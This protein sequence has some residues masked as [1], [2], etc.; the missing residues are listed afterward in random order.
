V[1]NSASRISTGLSLGVVFAENNVNPGDALCAE[2]EG[3]NLWLSQANEDFKQPGIGLL[4]TRA[5]N[6]SLRSLSCC[7]LSLPWR[8]CSDVG[9]SGTRNIITALAVCIA[10]NASSFGTTLLVTVQRGHLWVVTHSRKY[11]AQFAVSQSIS[12]SIC[13][14]MKTVRPSIRIAMSNGSRHLLMLPP[15]GPTDGLYCSECFPVRN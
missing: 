6:S 2:I 3:S 1:L 5:A 9:L 10:Q 8:C 11:P 4:L 14:P 13:L 12:Q 15:C 7:E